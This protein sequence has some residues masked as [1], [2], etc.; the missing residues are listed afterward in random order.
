MDIS[1]LGNRTVLINVQE[2]IR[3][4]N[5][6]CFILLGNQYFMETPRFLSSGI[7]PIGKFRKNN[8]TD[9]AVSCRAAAIEENLKV[10]SIHEHYALRQV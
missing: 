8:A 5:I 7:E 3:A 10:R 9:T 1:S 6:V 2:R 4:P